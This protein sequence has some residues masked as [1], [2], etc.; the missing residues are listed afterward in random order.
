MTVKS[1]DTESL[2][3]PRSR[4]PCS[5][6]T[7]TRPAR[8]STRI[9]T[10]AS[11]LRSPRVRLTASIETS[12]PE[13]AVTTMSPEMLAMLTRPSRLILTLGESVRLFGAVAAL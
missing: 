9:S 5:T 8:S 4:A 1:T 2:R 7:S 12:S 13:P 11:S 10:L 6:R 3:R